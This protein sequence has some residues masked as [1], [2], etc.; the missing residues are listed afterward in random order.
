MF[1]RFTDEARVIVLEARVEARRLGHDVIGTEH[2]LLGLLA[3]P[4]TAAA[5]YL[6][7]HGVGRDTVLTRLQAGGPGA[8]DAD[9]L[10]TLG[11][12]LDEIRRRMEERFGPGALAPRGRCRRRGA[13]VQFAARAK[14]T[15]ELSLREAA[16]GHDAHIRAEHVLLGLLHEGQGVAAAVMA[17]RGVT[18]AAARAALRDRRE[19]PAAAG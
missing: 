3:T 18:L 1:E 16:A 17:D 12:D 2:L 9:A 8:L 15:L 5:R 7:D 10:A 11:I 19:P 4:D 14:K 13:G 6:R